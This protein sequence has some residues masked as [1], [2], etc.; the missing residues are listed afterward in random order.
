[1]KNKEFTKV[2]EGLQSLIRVAMGDSVS[3]DTYFEFKKYFR[4]PGELL[5]R[6]E[7]YGYGSADDYL[8]AIAALRWAKNRK[9]D[10]S[11]M[12]VGTQLE[13]FLKKAE[14]KGKEENDLLLLYSVIC[15]E[16]DAT[17]ITGDDLA[18]LL[19]AAKENTQESV[20]YFLKKIL[21]DRI[22]HWNLQGYVDKFLLASKILV[23]KMDSISSLAQEDVCECADFFMDLMEVSYALKH[24]SE[25]FSLSI[26]ENMGAASDII[27]VF[28]DLYKEPVKKSYEKKLLEAGFSNMDIL[29]LNM[30]I[31]YVYERTTEL[32][33]SSEI[34]WW[35][36]AK[37]W[38]QS[39]FLQD[40]E[41]PFDGNR[42]M[43]L[44]D[45]KMPRK[46]DGE[47]LAPKFLLA[48]F[49]HG[50][51]CVNNSYLLFYI[52]TMYGSYRHSSERVNQLS[53]W[54]SICTNHPFRID[55]EDELEWMRGLLG[56]EWNSRDK[57]FMQ[58]IYVLLLR[59]YVNE[60]KRLEEKESILKEMFGYEVKEII[61]KNMVMFSREAMDKLFESGYLSFDDFVKKG[62]R[63]SIEKYLSSL[64]KRYILIWLSDFCKKNNCIFNDTWITYFKESL[65]IKDLQKLQKYKYLYTTNNIDLSL[66]YNHTYTFPEFLSISLKNRKL[67]EIYN[68]LDPS[69]RVDEKLRRIRQLFHESIRMDNFPEDLI[70]AVAK[71]LSK[72][73]LSDYINRHSYLKETA[74]ISDF[75][76]L[77]SI[78][79]YNPGLKEV[80]NEITGRIDILAVVNNYNN[81]K[82]KELGLKDF[83]NAYVSL[84][85]DSAWLKEELPIPEEHQKS[86]LEFCLQGNASVTKS[87]YDDQY[88]KGQKNVLLLAKA[89]VYGKLD[90]VKYE[91]FNAEI[92][93]T[94]TGD[95]KEVWKENSKKQQYGLKATEN[96]DFES[97]M[98][99]GAVPTWTCMNYKSG[100]YNECL[101]SVF[102]A[103]KKVLYVD[104]GSKCV[105]R[106][107]MR[108]T[109]MSDT[110]V[111]KTLS[112]RDV[113]ED[114]AMESGSD[115]KLVI[116]LE[117]MY[118]SHLTN[119]EIIQVRKLLYDLAEAKATALGAKILVAQDYEDI[120]EEKLL[121]KTS[122]NVYISKS[123][124]GDQYLDS[125][126][127]DCEK[128]GYYVK[129]N[130]YAPYEQ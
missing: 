80:I 63:G 120:A 128:G 13:D 111:N 116:F 29:N 66:F 26:K 47:D 124:N 42:L 12:C 34:K 105:A 108:L 21:D 20:V 3:N 39:L 71:T 8:S 96:T 95:Q 35:R 65:T 4:Y 19:D 30:G 69:M 109:K 36:L 106:A 75:L 51:P 11:E 5:E 50:I 74:S 1:M 84:D 81:P 118:F 103:N 78:E 32:Y 123:K 57:Y 85:E 127:G 122:T 126:G 102:D 58:R 101:L 73:P 107:I 79:S 94:L 121:K 100:Q 70:S 72:E 88:E 125:L 59:K 33:V 56:Y 113:A 62:S 97:C 25:Q 48:G 52:L 83:K 9:L 6:M 27:L 76:Y 7:Q 22:H 117:R 114:A 64:N 40:K 90:E 67:I 16:N 28:S 87:Y 37:R 38:F 17:E 99:I 53:L 82:L 18:T 54:E 112:F 104:K 68:S 119:A 98:K 86:F 14:E 91:N 115:E 93:F 46:I 60:Q 61:Y 41:V 2:Y 77:E 110:A 44:F 92:G 24:I 43:N 15:Y 129:G 10:I 31:W 55:S 130:F 45:K 49:A 23:L 89:A